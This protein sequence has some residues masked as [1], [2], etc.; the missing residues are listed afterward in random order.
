[1]TERSVFCS[2]ARRDAAAV[3]DIATQLEQLGQRAWLDER[4]SGGQAW[5]DTILGQIRACDCFLFVLSESS[6]QSRACMAELDYARDLG[7]TILPVVVGP[8]LDQLLPP[9]LAETQRVDAG[10]STRLARAL[11]SLPPTPAL[12][13]P[14]PDPPA[15]PISYLDGLARR[16]DRDELSTAEQ[17]NLEGELKQRLA[18]PDEHDAAAALLQRLRRH[19]S[20]NAW[21]AAEIDEDLADTAEAPAPDTAAAPTASPTTDQR[22]IVVPAE[23]VARAEP[24]GPAPDRAGPPGGGAGRATGPPPPAHMV[25]P[26]APPVRPPARPTERRA[27]KPDGPRRGR[28]GLVA[29]LVAL[30]LLAAGGAVAW[31]VASG[32][33]DTDSPDQPTQTEPGGGGP[34]VTDD[35]G[36]TDTT[37]TTASTTTT[38]EE[39]G[40]G[41][42][43]D[44]DGAEPADPDTA[45]ADPT[46]VGQAAGPP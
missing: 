17:R 19:P 44:T 8:V 26:P 27:D 24:V 36:T 18:D 2:Y 5:W 20:I 40:G 11:L 7:R 46:G 45:G 12:P 10:D 22:R 14:L 9:H 25:V 23:P 6:L 43:G 15:V 39:P 4:L 21:V 16:I 33:D 29:A 30:A 41:Q 35:P 13:D 42:E 28:V 3:D 31:I 1:M 38:T 37:D 32:G 34:E